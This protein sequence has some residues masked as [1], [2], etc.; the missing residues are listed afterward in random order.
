MSIATILFVGFELVAFNLF[1]VHLVFGAT[2]QQNALLDTVSQ[3]RAA[4]LSKV[5]SGYGVAEEQGDNFQQAMHGQHQL[6]P[7]HRIEFLFSG[8]DCLWFEYDS[9][10]PKKLVTSVLLKDGVEIE[11]DTAKLANPAWVSVRPD[12]SVRRPWIF[13]PILSAWTYINLTRI[14]FPG[15]DEKEFFNLEVRQPYVKVSKEGNSVVI[16]IDIPEELLRPILYIQDQIIKLNISDDGMLTSSELIIGGNQPPGTQ[17]FYVYRLNMT[18]RKSGNLFF[19]VDRNVNISFENNGKDTG[20]RRTQVT[21][22]KFIAG[23]VAANKFTVAALRI[24]VGTP[25]FDELLPEKDMR[26]NYTPAMDQKMLIG[27]PATTESAG[28]NAPGQ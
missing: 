5:T 27:T 9:N 14:P 13:G 11:Y 23:P 19:P 1:A 6:T 25:V 24:P 20:Y 3:M 17:F 18:W 22:T 7:L 21:F 2:A 8:N 12:E 4:A 28:I 26:F 10:D 15:P 16:D